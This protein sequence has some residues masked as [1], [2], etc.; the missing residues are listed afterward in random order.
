MSER[1]LRRVPLFRSEARDGESKKQGSAAWQGGQASVPEGESLE[2]KKP[3]D[4]VRCIAV[5]TR[6]S[7][8]RD[9]RRE[10]RAK[11]AAVDGMQK[12]SEKG[13]SREKTDE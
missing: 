10:S 8:K 11:E 13:V 5:N 2:R 4:D 7:C 3:P 1:P 12:R 6:T 9:Q